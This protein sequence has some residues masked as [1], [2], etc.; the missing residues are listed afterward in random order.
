MQLITRD[1][2][3]KKAAERWRRQY[4][5]FK[6]YADKE[7]TYHALV[8][9]GDTPSSEAVNLIIGNE[10]W[11]RLK[12]DNCDKEVESVIRSNT[13]DP[14]SISDVCSTCLHE[15]AYVIGGN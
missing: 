2:L 14:H 6:H 11:T 12:C 15:A 5:D 10:S 4:D 3:A 8:A 7:P 9:L 13:D 1:Y